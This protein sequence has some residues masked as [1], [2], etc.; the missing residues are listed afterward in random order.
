MS[1]AK[2]TEPLPAYDPAK[3]LY[4]NNFWGRLSHSYRL[5]HPKNLL[6]SDDTL[7]KMKQ[8]LD[9]YVRTGKSS[10]SNKELWNMHYILE[11]SL[12]PE[13]GKPVTKLFRWSAYCPV[14]IPIIIGLCVLPPTP[15]NQFIFQ[16]INQSYNFS[17]NFANSTSTNQKSKAELLTSYS[18]AVASALTGSIGLRKFLERRNLK[19][20]FGRALMAST[21]LVGLVFAN[22]VNLL[23][24]RS[25]EL[26]TGIPVLHPKTGKTIEGIRSR[27]AAELALFQGI[28]MRM[29]ISIPSFF[30]PNLAAKYASKHF[31]FYSKPVGR[32]AYDSTV[33]Y[34]S[35]WLCLVVAMSFFS[36]ISTIQLKHLEAPFQ[37]HLKE[38]KP[39]T[40]VP[41]NKGL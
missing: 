37:E 16:T 29:L 23:F 39:D 3:S 22:S 19:S 25:G 41:F 36:P 1:A 8:E 15:L 4:E 24:S 5:Y 30:I 13:T 7:L 10:K 34:L 14:N 6:Y 17:V 9:D 12:H 26:Q 33:A 35:I 27:K 18:L 28:L 2:P 38:Y 40:D 31:R 20:P 11:S 21:P 32:M